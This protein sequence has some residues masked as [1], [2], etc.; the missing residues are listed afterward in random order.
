MHGTVY[1]EMRIAGN[2]YTAICVYRCHGDLVPPVIWYPRYQI[3]GDLV[4][5]GYQITGAKSIVLVIWY[6][7]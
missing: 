4:P 2:V 3:T 6:L 1:R 5:Q 7:W